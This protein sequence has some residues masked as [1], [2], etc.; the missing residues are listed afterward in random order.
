[1][2]IERDRLA[3][4]EI[5]TILAAAGISGSRIGPD[6]VNERV[7]FANRV[8]PNEFVAVA[9]WLESEGLIRLPDPGD[10]AT[11]NFPSATLTAE[12]FE[13]LGKPSPIN[14]N[15]DVYTALVKH[16]EPA[17]RSTLAEF[18]GSILG[19]ASSYLN[20]QR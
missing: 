12:G 4:V 15:D 20:T 13:F 8:E 6:Q 5:L 17:A 18:I 11:G 10:L 2:T 16:T 19:S 14:P 7:D 1:M 9:C 3:A